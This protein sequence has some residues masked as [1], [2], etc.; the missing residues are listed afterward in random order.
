MNNRPVLPQAV[1]EWAAG[2]SVETLGVTTD[3]KSALYRRSDGAMGLRD[4]MP[5]KDGDKRMDAV[6]LDV[7]SGEEKRHV[8]CAPDAPFDATKARQ[9]RAL[10]S[11]TYT[12]LLGTSLGSIHAAAEARNTNRVEEM[13]LSRELQNLGHRID[14]ETFMDVAKRSMSEGEYEMVR[15]QLTRRLAGELFQGANDAD[16]KQRCLPVM[17]SALLTTAV[18]IPAAFTNGNAHLARAAAHT[19]GTLATLRKNNAALGAYLDLGG[20]PKAKMPTGMTLYEQ[21]AAHGNATALKMLE[22][23]GAKLSVSAK[24]FME[25]AAKNPAL[26]PFDAEQLAHFV[27]PKEKGI[28]LR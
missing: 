26:S 28:S 14:G 16:F 25:E 7:P 1:R 9:G 23:K 4:I 18:Q 19:L 22:D 2:L 13:L 6:I 8:V 5:T 17:K 10:D 11:S 24:A 12:M 20:N 3:G 21:A 15:H 27:Q